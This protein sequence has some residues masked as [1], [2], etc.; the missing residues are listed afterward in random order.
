MSR[1][2]LGVVF[3]ACT[4]G[5]CAAQPAG[6]VKV[7]S[8]SVTIE[9]SGEKVAAAVGAKVE[10]GDRIVTGRDSAVGITLRDGTLLSAGAESVLVIEKFLFDTTTHAGAVDASVKRG[11]VS[12]ISG[13]IAKQSPETVRFRTPNAILGVRGTTFVIDVG[14]TEA[15]Q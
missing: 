1:L 6:I 12:V 9:R 4:A 3:L 15:V 7:A 13:K 5:A 2:L 10:A 14:E 8:G 11:T